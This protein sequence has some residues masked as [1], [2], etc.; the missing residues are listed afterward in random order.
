M[1]L[2]PPHRVVL[3]AEPGCL[4]LVERL[5]HGAPLGDL[6]P[7]QERV[8]RELE[9]AG[10]L[11][12]PPSAGVRRGTV[13]LHDRGLE[14][15]GRLRDLLGAAG[16][17][18]SGDTWPEPPE[19]P[20][21]VLVCSTA[22]LARAVVDPWLA[23]GTPHLPVCGTGRPGSLRIGPLVE[24]GVTACLRCVDAAEAVA[25]PRRRLVVEQ[26]A[27][28][29][30]AP[31]DPAT[32]ALA[33]GWVVRDVAAYLDGRAPTTWSATVDIDRS[34]PVVTS[35]PRHPECGCCWDELPY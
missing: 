6:D 15:I 25:D 4:D 2:D 21:L 1:G 11:D 27:T 35:W 16:V 18:A 8:L 32:L 3:P 26:L 14:G 9:V 29:P 22:P 19:L 7:G 13:A 31:V 24:P 5:R 17:A 33:L 20:D 12:D 34:P 23:D 28:R 30:A 10:L